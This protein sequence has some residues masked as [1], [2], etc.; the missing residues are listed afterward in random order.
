MLGNFDLVISDLEKDHL[1]LAFHAS[2]LSIF[3]PDVPLLTRRIFMIPGDTAGSDIMG[4]RLFGTA[5]FCF[6]IPAFWISRISLYTHKRISFLHHM[7]P[8]ILH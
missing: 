2:G 5:N 8:G 7:V 4:H 3:P 6:Q 1:D